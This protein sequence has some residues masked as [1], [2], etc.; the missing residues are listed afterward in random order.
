M[1]RKGLGTRGWGLGI[2]DSGLGIRD[3]AFGI[4]LGLAFFLMGSAT[5]FA[6][7][8]GIGGEKDLAITVR[9]YDYAQV[10]RG[11]LIAAEQQAGSIFRKTGLTLNWCNVPIGTA[12][13]LLDSICGQPAGRARLDLRI[14]SRLKVVPGL[15]A[16]STMGFA[17][18]DSATVSY[19]WG[20]AADPRG[21]AMSWDILACVIAHEIG[22][23]LLGP[24]SHSPTGIMMGEWSHDAL[25]DA[26]EGRLR[27]TPQQ[28]ELIRAEVLARSGER[29]ASMAQMLASEP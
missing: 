12:E 5:A 17:W 10:R 2:K 22:H 24:N 14:V 13:S 18:G 21:E 6:A 27:F 29:R 9:V 16:D 3:W 4:V 28:A 11:A 7:A 1:E 26:G 23:V 8:S 25:R 19:H 20:K 15:T